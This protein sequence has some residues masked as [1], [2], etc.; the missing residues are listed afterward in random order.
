MATSRNSGWKA[1]GTAA[2]VAIVVVWAYD[3]YKSTGK[4]L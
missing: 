3:R 1:V 2:L 4:I